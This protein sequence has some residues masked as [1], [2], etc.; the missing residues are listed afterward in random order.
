MMQNSRQKYAQ[1]LLAGNE[2]SRQIAMRTPVDKTLP[3]LA[4]LEAP[5]NDE[6]LAARQRL[7]VRRSYHRKQEDNGVVG[8]Y[9]ELTELEEQLLQQN[10]A[11]ELSLRDCELFVQK[12]R[13]WVDTNQGVEIFD[14][15]STVD[16]VT[17]SILSVNQPERG[18]W[19]VLPSLRTPLNVDL[20]H[21]IVERMYSDIA[22]FLASP[23]FMTTGTSVFGWSDKRVYE[24]NVVKFVL[25][26]TFLGQST[27]EL[28]VKSF[29]IVAS[30]KICQ[31][32]SI[33]CSV[34]A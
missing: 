7:H 26:K 30:V 1:E 29:N 13:T 24:D 4:P 10:D 34:R 19:V 28:A 23:H 17:T 18:S 11:M 15:I 14:R 33:Q 2:A 9:T 27:L 12:V 32:S 21:T 20:C 6:E 5:L 8:L 25:E 16:E 31:C 22:S 3:T